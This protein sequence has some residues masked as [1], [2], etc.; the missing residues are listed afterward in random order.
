MMFANAGLLASYG[1][2]AGPKGVNNVPEASWAL[3]GPPAKAL[4]ACTYLFVACFAPTWGPVSW[5]YPP[6]LYP[7]RIRGKAVALSTSANWITNF[8]LTYFVPPA[9]VNVKWQVYIMWVKPSL[10]DFVFRLMGFSTSFGVFNAAMALHVFFVFP[11]T[12]GKTLEEIEGM[13]T[14]PNGIAGIGTPAW[15]TKKAY[16]RARE[17]EKGVGEEVEKGGVVHNEGS[18]RGIDDLPGKV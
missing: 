5:I 12:A 2:W 9:F 7:L 4:I 16:G 6:E 18:D 10:H 13:F 8:A 15:K 17:F 3:S 1:H 11:E 14:D